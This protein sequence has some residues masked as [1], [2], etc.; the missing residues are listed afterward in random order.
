MSDPNTPVPP[1]PAP[2]PGPAPT[3][4]GA[5][6]AVVYVEREPQRVSR[7]GGITLLMVLGVLQG[8]LAAA[9]GLFLVLENDSATLQDEAQMSSEQLTG[10]GIGMMVGGLIVLMLAAALGRGSQ[11]VRWLYGIVTMVNVSFAVWGVFSLHAEQRMS[12][13]FTLV[14]GLV[15]LWILFGSERND[16]F[17]A[18]D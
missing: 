12:A 13:V 17:F 1:P 11:I 3:V 7:P 9:A 4:P 16:R 5:Q 15:V 8:L 2:S 18:Q 6:P 14:F 10:A